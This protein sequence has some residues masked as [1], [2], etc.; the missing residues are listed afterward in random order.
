MTSTKFK[1]GDRVLIRRDMRLKNPTT[2]S[3]EIAT[4]WNHGSTELYDVILDKGGMNC[5][6]YDSEMEHEPPLETLARALRSAT[7]I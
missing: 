2:G 6:L 5:V 4:V 3:G 1:K 7:C